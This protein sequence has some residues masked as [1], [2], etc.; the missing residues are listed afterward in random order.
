MNQEQS[1]I[2]KYMK[3]KNRNRSIAS[4]IYDGSRTY[5]DVLLM[6]KKIANSHGNNRYRQIKKSNSVLS[7]KYRNYGNKIMRSSSTFSKMHNYDYKLKR[8]PIVFDN[9]KK[10]YLKNYMNKNDFFFS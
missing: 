1:N 6:D 8:A 10:Y 7:G 4:S 5:S 2:N 3:L 9:R